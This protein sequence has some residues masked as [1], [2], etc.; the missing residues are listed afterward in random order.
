[1]RRGCGDGLGEDLGVAAAEVVGVDGCGVV[2]GAL[3]DAG[4]GERQGGCG[5]G[6]VDELR[7]RIPAQTELGRGTQGFGDGG[8]ADDEL[9]LFSAL[10]GEELVAGKE[11]FAE[12]EAVVVEAGVELA[13]AGIEEGVDAMNPLIAMR[14]RWMGHPRRWMGHPRWRFS[15]AGED[16]EARDG[17]QRE[18][19][20]MAEALGGA[21]A[22]A[23]SGKRAGAVDDGYGFQLAKAEAA[24]SSQGVDGWDEALGGG[25]AGEGRYGERAG[26][27]GEGQA[28]GGA[29]GVDEQN[30]QNGDAS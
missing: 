3:P 21:E 20:G 4:E 15:E 8:L 29:T 30:L 10:F 1:L 22:D 27:V 25:A 24:A 26:G 9:S 2:E 5:G 18:V 11:G 17:D 14:L 6:F 16:G 7:G 28:A 13:A 23:H 19:E 12:A